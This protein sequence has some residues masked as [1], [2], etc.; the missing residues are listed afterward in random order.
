MKRVK[1]AVGA[2]LG[3]LLLVLM[4]QNTETVRT[5]VLSATLEMPLAFTLLLAIG[6]GFA[7]G[8]LWCFLRTRRAGEAAEKSAAAKS[9][10]GARDSSSDR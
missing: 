10:A 6:G 7:L 4:L 5:K 9:A 3:F 2:I 8:Y 1:I